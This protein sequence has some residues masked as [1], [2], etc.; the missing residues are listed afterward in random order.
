[1]YRK[2]NE[3]EVTVK[4]GG[5]TKI[6]TGSGFYDHML[7]LFVFRSGLNVEI[8]AKGDLHIDSHH[9]IEDVGITFGLAIAEML[10]DKTGITRYG[11]ARLPMDE[12]LAQVDLD[13]SGRPY[14]VFNA[15]IKD[16]MVEE[17]FRAFA[18]SA[19]ITLHINLLYGKNEHHKCE[20]VF[21]AA[22]LALGQ[23]AKVAG[24]GIPS[25]KGVI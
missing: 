16:E 11:S 9:T 22:G 2:T 19:G 4:I 8:S 25:T 24:G 5:L 21:K 23:A 20:A 6:D 1:V 18:F 17:F 12:C 15:D 13:I 10:G 7:E 3:T 14:L